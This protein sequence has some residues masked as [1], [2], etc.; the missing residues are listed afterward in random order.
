MSDILWRVL[1][2]KK[3]CIITIFDDGNQKYKNYEND[4]NIISENGRGKCKLKNNKN[5]NI[6]ID[7]ISCW[8]LRI[9]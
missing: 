1:E 5:M 3:K 9:K 4:W 6:V 7:S 8:K 2:E